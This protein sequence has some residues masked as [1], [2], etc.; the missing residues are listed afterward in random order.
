[1]AILVRGHFQSFLMSGL[2]I[3]GMFSYSIYCP[4]FQ[5]LTMTKSSLMCI[6]NLRLPTEE[7][8]YV[9]L[10]LSIRDQHISECQ[11]P[12]FTKICSH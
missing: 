4:A 5:I 2:E 9:G 7:G 11:L 8:V 1:M 3:M 12:S 10:I 6:S